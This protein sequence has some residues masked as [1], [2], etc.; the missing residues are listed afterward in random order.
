M[1]GVNAGFAVIALVAVG[2]GVLSLGIAPAVAACRAR[3]AS[4]DAI[5]AYCIAW[6]VS[7]P[8]VLAVGLV[9]AAWM[10]AGLSI[11]TLT[12]GGAR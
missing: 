3:Q 2:V 9:G 5:R 1:A 7:L 4:G 12:Y 6:L 10:I 8:P 11:G